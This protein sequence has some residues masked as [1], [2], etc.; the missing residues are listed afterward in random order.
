MKSWEDYVNE[1]REE[2]RGKSHEDIQVDTA[3]KW[4]ARAYASYEIALSADLKIDQTGWLQVAED[5]RHE[6]LEHAALIEGNQLSVNT[7]ALV[8]ELMSE[9]RDHAI[10]LVYAS[11]LEGYEPS[12]E[13]MAPLD[14][15]AAQ[16]EEEVEL[17]EE[18][19]EEQALGEES[20]DSKD[21]NQG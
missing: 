3:L 13:E 6:S 18:S 19:K 21:E 16:G 11:D 7:S 17:A 14:E 8:R 5:Y 12:G 10:E 1:A 2:I 4:A 20:G 15:E 9:L